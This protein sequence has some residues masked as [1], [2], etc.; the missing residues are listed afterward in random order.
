[1]V[2]IHLDDGDV[3]GVVVVPGQ[4]EERDAVFGFVEHSRVLE[5]AQVKL[6]RAAVCANAREQVLV[7]RERDI[8]D[9]LVV[10]NKLRVD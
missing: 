3:V 2:L 5:A 7:V 10:R 1:M 6:A 9:L 4:L 8:V